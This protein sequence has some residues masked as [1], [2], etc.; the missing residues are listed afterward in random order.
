MWSGVRI[1]AASTG[2]ETLVGCEDQGAV[3]LD[4]LVREAVDRLQPVL[5]HGDLH[6]DVRS[7]R[8]EM[9]ALLQHPLDVVRDDLGRHRT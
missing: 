3:G 2:Q 6:D 9:T 5:A 7:E 1:E 4:A 8:R